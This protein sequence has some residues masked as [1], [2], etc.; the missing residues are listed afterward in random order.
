M[1]RRT[2]ASTAA[3]RPRRQGARHAHVIV[4]T[5]LLA[6]EGRKVG[7][8]EAHTRSRSRNREGGGARAGRASRQVFVGYAQVAGAA[9]GTVVLRQRALLGSGDLAAG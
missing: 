9:A 7:H 4:R 1:R 8:T 6:Q 3:R 2:V 5:L